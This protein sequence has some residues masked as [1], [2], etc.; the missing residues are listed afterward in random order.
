VAL[1]TP[2]HVQLGLNPAEGLEKLASPNRPPYSALFSPVI[3]KQTNPSWTESR[4]WVGRNEL[5]FSQPPPPPHQRPTL[6]KFNHQK[7]LANQTFK[8]IYTLH[9]N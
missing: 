2:K 3:P 9:L 8:P 1:D 4:R 7:C 5:N 6:A